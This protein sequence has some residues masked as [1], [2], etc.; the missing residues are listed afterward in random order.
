MAVTGITV[1]AVNALKS[2]ETIWDAGHRGAACAAVQ[3]M[4][5]RGVFS[6]GVTRWTFPIAG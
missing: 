5:P 2:G 4:R 3:P 1:R 6:R